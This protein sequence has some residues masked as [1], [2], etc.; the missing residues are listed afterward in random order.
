MPYEHLRVVRDEP[1]NLRKKRRFP[2]YPQPADARQHGRTLRTSLAAVVQVPE[3]PGFDSR[4]L[5]RID[6]VDGFRPEAL[7]VIPG[8]SVVSQEDR[9]VVLLFSSAEA[10]ASVDQRLTVLARD[11]TVT[12]ASLLLAIQGFDAW[13]PEDRMG[14]A[15]AQLG[16]PDSADS[17]VDVELWPLDMTRERQ[18]MMAAFGAFLEQQRVLVLDRLD[19]PSLLMFKVRVSEHQLQALLGY[20][21]VRLVDLPPQFGFGLD[22]FQIDVNNLPAITPPPEG[23]PGICVLDTGLSAGHPLLG[24]AVGETANFIDGAHEFDGNGHG[25]R[26]AGLALYGNITDKL[27][28]NFRPELRLFAGK[29]FA[30]DGEDQ[31]R[32]VEKAVEEAVRYFRETYLC[33]VFCL[34]Y[35][36][37][38]KIYDGRHIRG[39]AYTLDRLSR[40]LDILFVVPTGNLQDS[41]LPDDALTGY[42]GYLLRDTHRLLDPATAVN[43]ITVGGLAE[44]ERDHE[45][46]RYPD[47]I[48]TSPLARRNQPSPFT[49]IGPSIAGAIKPDFVAYAGNMAHHHVRR[50]RA[51]QRLGVISTSSSFAQGRLFDE[52]LG[53][54]FAAPQVA[55]LAASIL[56]YLPHASA[57][58]I[59][60]ILGAHARIPGESTVLLDD[61]NDAKLALCGYGRVD[62]RHLF[63]SADGAVTLL[64]EDIIAVDHHHFYELPLPEDFWQGRRRAREISVALA[65]CPAV[66]TTRIGY[67]AVKLS[68]NVVEADSLEQ[69]TGWFNS[70]RVGAA[71]QLKESSSLASVTATTRSKGTLQCATWTYKASGTRRLFAVVTRQDEPWNSRSE[72]GEPYALAVTF[73]DLENPESNLYLQVRQRVQQREQARIRGRV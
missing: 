24:P 11:G 67:R 33:K 7:E 15:L 31:T 54:S 4:R 66:K 1:I 70:N 30:S 58:T 47:R 2:G 23:A 26:V 5:L 63:E 8:L 17:I 14:A 13:L 60:A 34:A 52:M 55:H 46:Q 28:D 48:E 16:L 21:D 37:L 69:V 27:P 64:G 44:F 65:Y 18:A 73:R 3:G 49:R 61:N 6:V 40:E 50:R 56:R 45:A 59:R 43:A 39:L 71:Q 20:R 25:T 32:F 72:D 51:S 9:S 19:Q 35:G 10:L 41:D 22:V 12:Y 38:N 36:D 62:Q 57:N 29:V 42:P 68:F 53:T